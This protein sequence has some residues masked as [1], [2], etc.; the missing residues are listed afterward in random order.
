MADTTL[1]LPRNIHACLFDLDGVLTETAKLHAKA[2]K[3]TFDGFL[4]ARAS[5]GVQPFVPFDSIGDYDCVVDSEPRSLRYVQAVRRAAVF[6]DAPWGVTAGPADE[7]R[8]HSADIVVS[9]LAALL[10][11]P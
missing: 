5:P 11:A 3:Q 4:A 2:G 7:P 9:D 1:G 8:R 6:E 10:E